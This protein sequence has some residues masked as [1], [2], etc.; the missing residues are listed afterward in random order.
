MIDRMCGRFTH[1]LTWRDIVAL[2]R[3]TDQEPPEG[4]SARYNLAPSQLA[5]VVRLDPQSAARELVMLK[6]GLVPFWAKEAKIGYSMINARAETVATKPSFREAFRQRR[7][8]VPASGFYEWRAE[9]KGPKQPYHFCCANGG[10]MTFAGLWERW[11]QPDRAQLETFAIIV[12]PANDQVG[13]Y[14]ERM[15]VIL[16]PDHFDTWLDPKA[17][18]PAVEALLQPYTGTLSIQPVSRA[19]NSPRN[20]GPELLDAMR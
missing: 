17:P 3:L 7:C 16:E 20:D 8:L 11:R 10:P 2:Y 9:G 1:A 19:V 6:W 14:H 15:P 4:W 12:G 5:P 13:P 18:R